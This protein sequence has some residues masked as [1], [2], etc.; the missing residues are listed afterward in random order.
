MQL[1]FLTHVY[2]LVQWNQTSAAPTQS[3]PPTAAGASPAVAAKLNSLPKSLS[4]NS[5]R[6]HRFTAVNQ[7]ERGGHETAPL[8]ASDFEVSDTDSEEDGSLDKS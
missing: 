2:T 1:S 5:H 4:K 6:T 8:R 3:T 7:E